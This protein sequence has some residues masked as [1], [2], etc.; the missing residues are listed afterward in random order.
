M[1]HFTPGQSETPVVWK[2]SSVVEH[3]GAFGGSGHYVIYRRNVKPVNN[4]EVSSEGA[5]DAGP[6]VTRSE[7]VYA[8]DL[9]VR[10]VT[11]E[12]AQQAQAYLLF[13]EKNT[14]DRD[15]RPSA[16]TYEGHLNGYEESRF[17]SP[18]FSP[19]LA[20]PGILN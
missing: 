1:K 4:A 13:Y 17:P 11:W 5:A 20:L 18:L 2:L 15:V 7:W 8:S 16:Q 19:I 9:D 6:P 12:E 10:S 3:R 14:C